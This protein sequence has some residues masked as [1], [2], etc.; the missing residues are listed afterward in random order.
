MKRLF[1]PLVLACAFVFAL[2]SCELTP[3]AGQ[4]SKQEKK[5][6]EGKEEG[7]DE[8]DGALAFV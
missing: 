2:A 1:H 5:G 8:G 6:D 4:D 7:D 3:Y